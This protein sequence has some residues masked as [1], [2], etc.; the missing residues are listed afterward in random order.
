MKAAHGAHNF[1]DRRARCVRPCCP[2]PAWRRCGLY[3]TGPSRGLGRSSSLLYRSECLARLLHRHR[4]D[5]E[6]LPAP[7]V[8]STEHPSAC[9]GE[10]ILCH[11][12]GS[13]YSDGPCEVSGVEH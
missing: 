2:I 10:P 12:A 3:C 7:Q 11:I 6:P 9:R 8:G 4:F 5:G 13:T 1:T